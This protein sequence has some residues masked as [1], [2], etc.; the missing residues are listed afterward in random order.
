MIKSQKIA[1]L[2]AVPVIALSVAGTTF[3]LWPDKKPVAKQEVSH[4][5]GVTPEVEQGT[6]PA[7]AQT[8][9]T[10]QSTVS[11]P[12]TPS[13]PTPEENKTAIMKKIT[14][15]AAAKGW[16]SSVTYDQTTCLD[17]AI[18]GSVG[19]ANY[20]DAFNPDKFTMLNSYLAGKFMFNGP[21]TC[22]QTWFD[23]N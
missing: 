11:E 13:T 9:Q 10:T 2:I 18:S 3:A 20:D 16:N 8:T 7:S 1:L 17:R 4:S 15:Y 6:P 14:D 5:T 21:T 19:Y 23:E 12:A 22:Q